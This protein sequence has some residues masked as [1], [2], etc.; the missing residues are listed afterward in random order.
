M[1]SILASDD[2]LN[3]NNARSLDLL[4]MAQYFFYTSF[5]YLYLASLLPIG[6]YYSYWYLTRLLFSAS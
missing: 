5:L 3:V 2:D 4:L 1:L 6:Q